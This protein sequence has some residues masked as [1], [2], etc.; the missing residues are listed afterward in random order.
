[1]KCWYCQK[2]MIWGGDHSYE[3]YGFYD[4]D[5]IIANLSCSSCDAF[6]YF[7]I[8]LGERDVDEH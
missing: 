4:E 1:M 5:G 3:D 8:P 7:H 6:C 2:E